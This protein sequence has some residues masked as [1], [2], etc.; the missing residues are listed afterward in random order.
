[1]NAVIA[2]IVGF[3]VVIF[4]LGLIFAIPTWLLWNWLMPVIFGLPAISLLQA[5]G[6]NLLAG[7]LFK[8]ST[9]VEKFSSRWD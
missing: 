2:G 4:V 6:L 9:K 8:S 3:L 7:F 1:M 5:L